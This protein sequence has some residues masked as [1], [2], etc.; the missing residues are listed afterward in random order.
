MGTVL[1]LL[2]HFLPDNVCASYPCFL[3]EH[4]EQQGLGLGWEMFLSGY[5]LSVQ[6]RQCL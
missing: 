2:Q 6:M 5:R 4:Y 3:G 1:A